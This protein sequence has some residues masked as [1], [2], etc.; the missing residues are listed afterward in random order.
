GDHEEAENIRLNRMKE[1]GKKVQVGLSWTEVNG[2]I[3]QFKAHDRS[4]SQSKEIYAE[5]ER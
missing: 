1:V 4:H 2:E 3:V 5:A